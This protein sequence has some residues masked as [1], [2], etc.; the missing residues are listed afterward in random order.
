[1]QFSFFILLCFNTIPATSNKQLAQKS[2]ATKKIKEKEKEKRHGLPP[3][4]RLI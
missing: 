2:E 1:M 3:K 4:K